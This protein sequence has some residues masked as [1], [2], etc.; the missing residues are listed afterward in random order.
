MKI[1]LTGANGY[2]GA[3]MYQELLKKFEV[4]G[5]YN[6]NQ[7][8]PELL[9]LDITDKNQVNYLIQLVKPDIIIHT[10]N[11]ASPT[12]CEEHPEEAIRTNIDSTHYIVDAANDIKAKIIYISSIVVLN[13]VN[14]YSKS[15]KDSEE[16]VRGVTAGFTII[17]P[18]LVV[19]YSP[20]TTNDRSFN[21]MLKNITDKASTEYDNSWK[22]QPTY[23]KHLCGVTEEI[24]ERNIWGETIP[25]IVDEMVTGFDLATN[26]LTPFGI[27]VT[28]DEKKKDMSLWLSMDT[29]KL[30]ELKLP[31][32]GY[33][34]MIGKI[35]EEIKTNLNI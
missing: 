16:I 30:Q 19:G 26:I 3:K 32:C 23:L 2:V 28:S 18:S 34:E 24:I 9:K 31:L 11:N 13:P 8:F 5:T 4:V 7:L 22:F 17:R 12:W 33:D 20:N 10:A 35:V 15:K 21:R 25:V 27:N 1:L 14:I 6:S 29:L